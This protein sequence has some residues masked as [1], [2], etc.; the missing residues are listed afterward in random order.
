[1]YNIYNSVLIPTSYFLTFVQSCSHRF[2][3]RFQNLQKSG[4]PSG[5]QREFCP[6]TSPNNSGWDRWVNWCR[7]SQECQTWC[8]QAVEW[9]PDWLVDFQTSKSV[10]FIGAG[11]TLE[12]FGLQESNCSHI[13][14]KRKMDLCWF[15]AVAGAEKEGVKRIKRFMARSLSTGLALFGLCWM[16]HKTEQVGEIWSFY[17]DPTIYPFKGIPHTILPV[18]W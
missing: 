16:E 2:Q 9:I 7:W 11:D 8:Q 15:A 12:R 6:M 4:I 18:F 13:F 17:P 5:F 3:H 10:G 14:L 1:M